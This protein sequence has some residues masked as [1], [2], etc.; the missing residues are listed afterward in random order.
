MR[1]MAHAYIHELG[2]D[3]VRPMDTAP[4]VWAMMRSVWKNMTPQER[5]A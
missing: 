1:S 5:F 4:E 3:G 2:A